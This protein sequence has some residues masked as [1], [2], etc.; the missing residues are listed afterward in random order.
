M[1]ISTKTLWCVA[2][3]EVDALPAIVSLQ[4]GPFQSEETRLRPFYDLDTQ[5]WHMPKLSSLV[6]DPHFAT[7]LGWTANQHN[8]MINENLEGAIL[9]WQCGMWKR[10]LHCHDRSLA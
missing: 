6:W 5:F 7:L 10:L 4:R 2:A 8:D 9:R 1:A 3:L